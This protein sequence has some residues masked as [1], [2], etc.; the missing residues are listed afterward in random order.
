MSDGEAVEQRLLEALASLNEIGAAINRTAPGDCAGV[1]DTLRLIVASAIRVT[2]GAAAV[3][4]TYDDVTRSFDA[5]SRVSAGE[6]VAL[7]QGDEPRAG[8]LGMRAIAERRRIL[9]YEERASDGPTIHPA[10]AQ[11]GARAVACFPLLVAD[12]AMGALYVYLYEERHFSPFELV[13]LDNLV[14][15]AAMAIYHA[16]RLASVR[17]DL[18]RKEDELARLRRAGLLI[19]SRLRLEETLEAILQMALEVTGAHFGIFRLTDRAGENLVTR[20][21]AGE[22]L[23]RPRVE[24][25]PLQATSV[26][27][28]VARQRQPVCIRDL[29]EAP[30]RDIYYPLDHQL[31][32]RSELAVPLVGASGRLEGVLNLES[33]QVGAFDEDDSHLLQALATQAVIAIQEARLL[34]ALQEVAGRLLQEPCDRVLTRLAELACDLLDAADSA[35]WV[36]VGEDLVLRAASAGHL[37]GE[38]VPL[39]GSLSG[40]AIVRRR[41]VASADVQHDARFHQQHMAR[42]RGWVQ[43]LVAPMLAAGQDEPA[44]AI[45]VY[46]RGLEPR[47]A[48]AGWDEK[49]LSCLA[50]YAALAVANEERQEALRAAQEQRAVAETFA[51]VGDIA[52]N[53]LHQLNN[54]VG[55]IPVRV[56]GI[57]ERSA[58][59]LLADPYLQANLIEIER[60][61]RDAMEAVRESLFHLRPIQ[62][63]PTDLGLCIE[64]ALRQAG[65]P[66]A[67]QVSMEGLDGLPAVYAG[68]RTLALVF[69]NLLENASAAMGGVGE[70]SIRAQEHGGWV[71]V[72]VSDTGPGI[73][74]ELHERIF[75]LS[76]SGRAPR[77]PGKLGFGLWWVK[78]LMG[79]LGGTVAVE[80]DGGHGASFRLRLPV[81]LEARP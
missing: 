32:M 57:Q 79:R 74:P 68:R 7:V 28:W 61:A 33:P 26:M 10:I 15:H 56:Q 46:L 78:T 40:E 51:A 12:E 69:A 41:P 27:A 3:I 29:R 14:N 52:A 77:Q 65:L 6:R 64:A 8:G 43:A 63:E 38:R 39:H 21:V 73:A 62:R 58:G 31:E 13:A 49:V 18:A 54:K 22:D 71:E 75:E 44:G 50:H 59:A 1:A 5:H 67:V 25:L 36:L 55:T 34:D 70:I 2:P 80:S 11:A 42:S 37:T 16:R 66:G 53:L 48:E 35:I 17:R 19:S 60:S 81:H 4:Y 23:I 24:V 76:Y 20:A 72:A 47:L 45:T 30:W 9:S